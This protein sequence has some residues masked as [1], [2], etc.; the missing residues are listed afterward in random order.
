MTILTN[1]PSTLPVVVYIW[2][3]WC[4]PC[5]T[6]SPAI[7]RAAEKFNGQV[8]LRKIN[9][10]EHIDEIKALKIMG[11]PTVI[12]Y[13]RQ[14]HEVYRRTGA[15]SEN[16]L[17][18][19]FEQALSEKGKPISGPTQTD[20]LLRLGAAL[21]LLAIAFTAPQAWF[22]AL[23]AGILGFSAVYDRCPIYSAVSDYLKEKL[24]PTVK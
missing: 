22:L 4:L 15:M 2:A 16:D 17:V 12:L 1:I 9:A 11:V 24:R 3:S 20:R 18:K 10:D 7:T 6:M 5:K 13:H 8:E 14:G 23:I 19:L 21:G